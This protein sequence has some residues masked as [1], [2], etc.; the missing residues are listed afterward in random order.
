MTWYHPEQLSEL[1]G[2]LVLS[3]AVS[4][5]DPRLSVEILSTNRRPLEI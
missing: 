5:A 1:V 2:A 3:R 4:G